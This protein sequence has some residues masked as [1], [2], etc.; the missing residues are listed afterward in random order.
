MNNNIPKKEKSN[1]DKAFEEKI[2]SIKQSKLDLGSEAI[3]NADMPNIDTIL[4]DSITKF[5]PLN[6]L[7]EISYLM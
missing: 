3:K 7:N 1:I 6:Q 2:K 4:T 5:V